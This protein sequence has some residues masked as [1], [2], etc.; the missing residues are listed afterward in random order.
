MDNLDFRN[1]ESCCFPF[2]W[3]PRG[4]LIARTAIKE[5][6]FPTKKTCFISMIWSHLQHTLRVHQTCCWLSIVVSIDLD[7]FQGSKPTLANPTLAKVGFGQSRFWPKLAI[8]LKHK[9]WPKS[10]WPKSVTKKGWPNSVGQSRIGQ[11]RPWP[12]QVTWINSVRILSFY[13]F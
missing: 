8:P 6:P 11:S 4:M 13:N 1:P 7:Y 12:F 3:V 9:R 2:S 10:D 5:G